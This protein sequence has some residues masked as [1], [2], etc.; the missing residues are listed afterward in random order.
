[1][2][3][4]LCNEMEQLQVEAMEWD[5]TKFTLADFLPYDAAWGTLDHLALSCRLMSQLLAIIAGPVW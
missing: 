4:I 2:G 5:T 1:M 3:Y